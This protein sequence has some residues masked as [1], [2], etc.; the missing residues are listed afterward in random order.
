MKLQMGNAWN[1]RMAKQIEGFQF[2]VGI[3]R[4]GTHARP[5][6]KSEGTKHYAG[7]PSRKVTRGKNGKASIGEIL[8]YNM[9]RTNTNF[10]SEPFKKKSSDIM[11]FTKEFLRLAFRHKGVGSKRVENLLQ[12]VVRNPI[13]KLD[14]GSNSRDAEKRKGFNRHLFDTA[15]M[16][17]AIRARIIKR[18]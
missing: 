17:K 12:A 5:M 9:K 3:L 8:V 18:V 7:G 10:L 1:K 15:Q 11:R 4:D 2:E 13:L 14:Y 6:S 16:F